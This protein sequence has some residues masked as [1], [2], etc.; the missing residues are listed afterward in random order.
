MVSLEY[1]TVAIA[2]VATIFSLG[3]LIISLRSLRR[4]HNKKL[5][6]ISV[7]LSFFFAKSV[8]VSFWAFTTSIGEDPTMLILG[9][10]DVFILLS[11]Y[12]AVLT[13]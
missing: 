3:L 13:R 1:P 12:V 6:A 5:V 2:G 8:Y 10:F 9:C 11:L 4:T 7:L